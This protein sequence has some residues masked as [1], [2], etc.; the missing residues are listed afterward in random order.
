MSAWWQSFIWKPRKRATSEPPPAPC[1]HR[2]V[3][4][5]VGEDF[6]RCAKC[7]AVTEVSVVWGG[8][9]APPPVF[10]KREPMVRR[11]CCNSVANGPHVGPCMAGLATPEPRGSIIVTSEASQY[12][13]AAWVNISNANGFH[14]RFT[15]AELTAS[16]TALRKGISNTPPPAQYE[17][18][19]LTSARLARIQQLLGGHAMPITSGYRSPE[20]NALV[21]G[22]KNS[23]HCDGDAADFTC[24]AFGT[25]L[26]VAT[27]IS[28]LV[29][30]EDIDQLIHEY[31]GWVHVS[32]GPRKRG[33]L[34][35]IDQKGTREGLLPCR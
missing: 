11:R 13:D 5:V 29:A 14:P 19:K 18:L 30:M 32:F 8:N 20:L 28:M 9:R 3:R 1:E 17:R 12:T 34:L 15:Y 7:N 27:A 35:T 4:A 23:A 22:S 6:A 25:P 33:Q 16:S 21:G 31:G 26:V 2:F 10:G 24:P